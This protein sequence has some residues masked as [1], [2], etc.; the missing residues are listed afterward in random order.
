MATTLAKRPKLSGLDESPGAPSAAP[1][2]SPYSPISLTFTLNVISCGFCKEVL[3]SCI[4]QCRNHHLVC[5]HCRNTE[6][7]WCSCPGTV[8]SFR[9]EALERLVGCFSVLCSN[10]SFGCP[11]AFPIY[12]RRAHETKCSFAP[13][14]CASCSFTGAASQFSAHFSDHH[15]WNI[16]EVPDYNVEFGMALKASE[17]RIIPVRIGS[18]EAMFLIH[19]EQQGSSGRLYP[20]EVA[21]HQE[22]VKTTAIF[23]M[24]AYGPRFAS[25]AA[26]TALATRIYDNNSHHT[27]RNV[28]GIVCALSWGILIP[29][30][31]RWYGFVTRL[32]VQGRHL[33]LFYAVR[34][35]A[36]TLGFG[37]TIVGLWLAGDAGEIGNKAHF[38]IAIALLVLG[39]IGATGFQCYC[40]CPVDGVAW[41][42]MIMGIVNVFKGFDML[43]PPRGYRIAYTV[44]LSLGCVAG[45]AAEILISKLE[46]IL[47]LYM[48]PKR[49]ETEHPSL[50][51]AV[52]AA[53]RA[54]HNGDERGDDRN[55]GDP[56]H[57]VRPEDPESTK[58]IGD[59]E[60]HDDEAK[61]F[62]A[63]H[64][65]FDSHQVEKCHR[66]QRDR[67]AE[68][69]FVVGDA[70]VRDRA[71]PEPD[72]RRGRGD[73]V[74]RRLEKDVRSRQG[75]GQEI[76]P[77]DEHWDEDPP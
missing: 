3:V 61:D 2:S 72:R 28:H 51:A 24:D 19:F 64:P 31:I 75:T 23:L 38:S 77:V 26:R 17:A 63:P 43:D 55:V 12:A 22:N 47:G 35:I 66:Q 60:N 48:P 54:A 70:A 65:M 32:Q 49:K 6:R 68:V 13:R 34:I 76:L 36:Y 11:D 14:R 53:H 56:P 21:R 18:S 33:K 50:E 15:R 37:G 46:I 44:V 67:D 29:L 8:E 52:E 30:V 40:C 62:D 42:V 39:G 69:G 41:A 5:A 9:N 16:I 25:S 27:V 20:S 58:H 59:G 73:G 74:E 10:S 4:Y 7:R 71:R 45:V 1:F 57:A